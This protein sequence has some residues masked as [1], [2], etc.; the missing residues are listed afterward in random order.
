MDDV[1]EQTSDDVAPV[2]EHA[3]AAAAVPPWLVVAGGYAWRLA[4]IGVVAYALS[5]VDLIPDWIPV[6]GLLDDLIL[7]PIGIALVL[8]LLPREVLDASRERVSGEMSGMER[9]RL[10]VGLLVVGLWIATAGAVTAVVWM[11]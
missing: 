3:T 11:I 7:V 9:P 8:N 6:L 4:A 2:L 1:D 10:A 5:P